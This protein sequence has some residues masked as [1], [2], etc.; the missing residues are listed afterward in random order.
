MSLSS[1][2]NLDYQSN[3]TTYGSCLV[4]LFAQNQDRCRQ[5]GG[6]SN[7]AEFDRFE[8]HWN[9]KPADEIERKRNHNTSQRMFRCSIHDDNQD[10]RDFTSRLFWWWMECLVCIHSPSARRKRQFE[11]QTFEI[12][13]QSRKCNE[14]CY[15][16]I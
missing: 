1:D 14:R 4:W 5:F 8:T 12:S 16:Q 9:G 3:Q 2:Y 11:T 15:F 7:A 10:N 13:H 6:K